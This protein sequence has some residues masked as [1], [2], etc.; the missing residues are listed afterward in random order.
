MTWPMAWPMPWPMPWPVEGRYGAV[1]QAAVTGSVWQ[2]ACA[3]ALR[4]RP[5]ERATETEPITTASTAKNMKFSIYPPFPLFFNIGTSIFE[6]SVK[7][8]SDS[9]G[10]IKISSFLHRFM[11][12]V[13]F[14]G[15]PCDECD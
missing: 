8:D 15:A 6:S 2:S 10:Q 1:C 7:K 12:L 13:H 3:L 14:F 11:I 4:R 9:W 5:A